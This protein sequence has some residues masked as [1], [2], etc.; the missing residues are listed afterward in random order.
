MEKLGRGEMP[1]IFNTCNSL[2]TTSSVGV[3]EK[4]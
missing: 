3:V 1:D 2:S 4:L